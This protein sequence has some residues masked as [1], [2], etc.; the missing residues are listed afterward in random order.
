MTDDLVHRR[1]GTSAAARAL[2]RRM[3]HAGAARERRR[4]RSRCDA[5]PSRP[6]GTGARRDPRRARRDGRQSS[7]AAA[8][9]LKIS[10][11]TLYEKL[12]RYPELARGSGLSAP[13]DIR[14]SDVRYPDTARPGSAAGAPTYLTPQPLA[15]VASGFALIRCALAHPLRSIPQSRLTARVQLDGDTRNE[16]DTW[17]S[18]AALC[19]AA[20]ARRPARLGPGQGNQDRPHLQPTGPLEAYGKQT[21]DR[22]HDGPGLR[23][24]RH[25]DGAAARSSSSSRRTTRASPTWASACSPPPTATTR[26]TSPSAPPP[27]GVALAMLPVAE[28]YKKVLLV[29]PA[30]ADSITGDKWNKYIFRTGR[31]SSQ[32]AISNAVALDK[33]GVSIATLAQDYAFGRDGVKAFKESVKNA[34]IVHEEYLP[35]TTTDFTAGAQRLIDKLKDQPG[36]KVIWIVWAGAGN[37]FKIADLDLQALRHRDRHRRQHPARDGRVQATS[38]AWKAPPTTTS[39][40]RRTRPTS[41]W[42]PTTTAVQ[43][44]ARLLHRRR[45]LRRDGRRHGAEEDQRRHQHRQADRRDGRHEL[46]HAQGQDDLPQGR[47]PGHAVDVPLQD[48]G[49]PGLRLGR[50]RAGAARSSPRRWRCRSATSAERGC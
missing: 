17:V 24:Q 2:A 41:G 35:T 14:T 11:A 30:V 28:E 22:L 42:W 13:T 8:K 19:A 12:A 25:H 34:K 21:A 37:P 29:E 46:R 18:A 10:R 26:S 9:L 6:R 7:V 47:P 31:N 43:E 23:H 33:A 16:V 4:R 1:R 20:A 50:A 44:P 5:A 39:A 15:F 48:Q 45:L 38:P 3:R 40:S 36:R 32:D 27:R 49:R